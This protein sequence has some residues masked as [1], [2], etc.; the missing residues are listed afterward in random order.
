MRYWTAS[1]WRW[2]GL[3]S[4]F[5]LTAIGLVGTARPSFAQVPGDVGRIAYVSDAP[6]ND[7][8]NVF[9][10]NPDG[11]GVVQLTHDVG[12]ADNL[13]PTWSPDGGQIAF[14]RRPGGRS[15][16]E[17]DTINAG[18][19]GQKTIATSAATPAWSPNGKLLAFSCNQPTSEWDMCVIHPDGSG[20]K[21]ISTGGSDS[22][23][24]WSPNGRKIAFQR[25]TTQWNIWVMNADGS[26][27]I[28]LTTGHEDI[29]PQWSPDGSKIVFRSARTGPTQVFVMARDGSGQTNLS[30]GTANDGEPAWSPDG[31]KIV[32]DSDRSP[33]GLFTMNSDGSAVTSIPIPGGGIE[34]SWQSIQLTL[35]ASATHVPPGGSVTLTAHLFPHQVTQNLTVT[36]YQTPQGG[37]TTVLSSGQVDGSGNFSATAT[38]PVT[39]SFYAEWT[40][41]ARHPLSDSAQVTV[42][43]GAILFDG[44]CGSRCN[45]LFAIFPDGS[46]QTTVLHNGAVNW[47]A[48]WSP[49]GTKIAFVSNVG[50]SYQVFTM[51]AD[52]SGRDQLTHKGSINEFPAW[53]PD[54]TKIA[55][56]S[57]R[58]G[59]FDVYTMLA[60]GTGVVDVTNNPRYDERPDW[61]PDGSKI[62]FDSNRSGNFDI[63]VQTLASGHLQQVTHNPAD[64]ASPVFSPNGSEIA[65]N[66]NR[67]GTEDIWT[68]LATGT[69]GAPVTFG[70]AQD[71]FPNWS[72]DGKQIAFDSNRSGGNYNIWYVTLADGNV[73][74]VTNSDEGYELPDWG[75]KSGGGS[76]LTLRPIAGR[77]SKLHA[78]HGQSSINRTASGLGGQT[79]TG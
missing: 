49:D 25:F 22:N 61:S 40:G 10:A 51:N 47:G 5:T 18:G 23:P 2:A 11:T 32:F 58:S 45:D 31:S 73:T 20:L 24:A 72:P 74:A 62:V 16:E 68:I 54:G 55:F 75:P 19:S 12:P 43:T 17:I 15:P 14:E 33:A 30:D 56:D 44:D 48:V 46:G 60:A 76:E 52:G 28:Q 42:S 59:N 35:T 78:S 4:L 3:I 1:A 41:D 27:P 26:N 63:W 38:L 39:T 6:P 9:T 70:P 65:W 50:N 7:T 67:N 69:G 77:S 79:L 13:F 8:T 21:I 36:I 71:G 66:S 29:E 53:S 57:N 37:S 34:P 64:D